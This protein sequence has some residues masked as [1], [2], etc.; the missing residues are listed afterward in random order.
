MVDE[1]KVTPVPNQFEQ[2]TRANELH[3]L[4][5]WIDQN[6]SQ[7]LKFFDYNNTRSVF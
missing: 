4:L 7:C 1:N 2:P 3:L 5:T 6:C